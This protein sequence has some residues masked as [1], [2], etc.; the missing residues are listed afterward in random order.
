[1]E[2]PEFTAKFSELIEPLYQ[3]VFAAGFQ[4]GA[5]SYRIRMLE[6]LEASQ[7]T[8]DDNS[9][10]TM[11][12]EDLDFTVRT[13]NCLKREGIHTVS[14]LIAKSTEELHEI[15]NFGH[16]CIYEVDFGL[17]QKGLKRI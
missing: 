16:K 12:I 9:L 1:M 7:T 6:M 15:R 8:L 5:K 3:A 13:Y 17:A 4:A 10:S 2:L 14:E 11:P